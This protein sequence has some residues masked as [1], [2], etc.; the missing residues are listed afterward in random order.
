MDVWTEWEKIR[1]RA[2]ECQSRPV[3]FFKAN[4][5]LTVG[6]DYPW[7]SGEL[8]NLFGRMGYGPGDREYDGDGWP[9][10]EPGAR[11][12]M[13]LFLRMLREA[14]PKSIFLQPVAKAKNIINAMTRVKLSRLDSAIWTLYGRI[15]AYRSPYALGAARVYLWIW[16]DFEQYELAAYGLANILV[17][18]VTRRK[19]LAETV[20]R[21]FLL[22]RERAC[23]PA[24]VPQP[25]RQIIQTAGV[26]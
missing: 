14:K 22:Q 24:V 21:K 13:D 20:Q 6:R 11:G 16:R 17:E 4:M 15:A 2:H 19:S 9:P 18:P 1:P 26:A 10:P 23:L 25:A 7:L 8:H 12:L 5:S 3:A